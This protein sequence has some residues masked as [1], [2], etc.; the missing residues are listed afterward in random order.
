M[1]P[2]TLRI[3]GRRS[4]R[5]GQPQLEWWPLLLAADLYLGGWVVYFVL[6][7]VVGNRLWEI[8]LVGQGL[9]WL[10]L[11]AIPVLVVLLQQRRWRR[12]AWGTVPVIALLALYGPLWLPR[13]DPELTCA[14]PGIRC[15]TL[16]VMSYNVGA[17]LAVPDALVNVVRDS[18]ADLIGL[19]EVAPEQAKA[20]DLH[21]RDLYPYQ[22]I[23]D[24]GGDGRAVL[25][26]YPVEEETLVNVGWEQVPSY[27]HA[28]LN[29]DG[30]PLSVLVVRA[31]PPRLGG[32]VDRYGFQS[33]NSGQ[34][35]AEVATTDEPS[36]YIPH[37]DRSVAATQEPTLLMTDLNIT[38]QGADYRRYRRAGLTD[39]FRAAGRG[40]GLTF[41]ARAG[42]WR[43][44]PGLP[45]VRIDYVWV[46]DEFVV[47]DAWV[48]ADAGSDHLPVLARV[49]WQ[50]DQQ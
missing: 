37:L 12:A 8:E 43:D 13:P 45:L 14:T 7:A 4:T 46:T 20:L 50:L 3:P 47:T 2:M 11:T 23:Y 1:P 30:S 21:T 36:V 32:Y 31:H 44:L 35:V 24:L 28:T 34:V 10:L 42:G 27:L 15:R 38:D 33:W 39:A 16:T 5:Q 41:P 49:V 19:Q 9:H 29:V 6:R 18:G 22:V 17:G 25:S 48:G 26:R 40:Y